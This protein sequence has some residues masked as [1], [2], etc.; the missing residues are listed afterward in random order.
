MK[1]NNHKGTLSA[2]FHMSLKTP[3]TSIQGFANAI[4]DGT[5]DDEKSIKHAAHVIS[6]E[7]DRMLRLVFGLAYSHQT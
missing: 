2:M 5:A 6:T 4:L 7:S 1:V 3:L